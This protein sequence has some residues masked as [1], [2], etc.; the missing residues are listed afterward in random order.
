MLE[1]AVQQAAD[2]AAVSGDEVLCG[3]KMEMGARHEQRVHAVGA[4][5]VHKYTAEALHSN[6]G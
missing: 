4:A 6:K 2:G 5:M 3:T 1:S